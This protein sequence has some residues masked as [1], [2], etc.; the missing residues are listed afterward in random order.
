MSSRN[1][2]DEYPDFTE[3]VTWPESQNLMEKEGFR[4]NAA[5]INSPHGLDIYGSSAYRV[6]PAWLAKVESGEIKDCEDSE[7]KPTDDDLLVDYSFPFDE[8]D[9]D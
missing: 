2:L 8:D 3:V 7:A 9:E 6:N 5:L 1:S 4:E